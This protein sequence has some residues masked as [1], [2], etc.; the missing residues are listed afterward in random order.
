[1][2][3]TRIYLCDNPQYKTTRMLKKHWEQDERFDLITDPYFN[4]IKAQWADATWIEW[5][6]TAI[7]QAADRQVTE[8]NKNTFNGIFD[9]F[10]DPAH[11]HP[12][13]FI[14]DWK[15]TKLINRAIDIDAYYGHYR[16]VQW[17]NVDHLVFI[18]KHIQQMVMADE[19]MKG[20]YPNLQIHHIPLSIDLS[21]WTYK[22][23]TKNHGKNIAFVHHLWAG[24][25]IVQGLQA[26]KKVIDKDPEFKLHIVGDW[27]S[28]AWFPFYVKHLIKELKL[29]DKITFERRVFSVDK[30]LD[31]MDYVMVA[32]FKEAFSLIT[33]EG[34]AKGLKPLIHNWI[35]AKDIWPI[36][37]VWTTIDE[38]VEMV[39]GDYSS[40]EYREYVKKYDWQ[41]EYQPADNIIL[42]L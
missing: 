18:A 36:K 41:N 40:E 20:K 32:S 26:F 14:G 42:N 7:A 33:A 3:K 17:Q 25:G 28:E 1:M 16:N 11:Q 29:E 31:D 34:M 12:I 5:C 8:Q 22:D 27:S 15:N 37:Y 35:G 10:I 6:E 23:R 24:K 2:R 13:N 21:E 38:F 4:P 9:D 39:F 19:C 30:F